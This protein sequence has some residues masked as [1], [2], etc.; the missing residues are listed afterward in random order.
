MSDFDDIRKR[1][2]ISDLDENERKAWHDKFVKAGGKDVGEEKKKKSIQIDR[3][4]QRAMSE[5]VN[6]RR[7]RRREE[8]D[9]R[10]RNKKTP[11]S[12][13]KPAEE[14]VLSKFFFKISLY[15]EGVFA[16]ATD[17]SGAFINP[18]VLKY[19]E[20]NVLEDLKVS[21]AFVGAI[22]FPTGENEEDA[23]RKREVV[24]AMFKNTVNY[25]LLER[26][27]AMY[28][29]TLYEELLKEYRRN[30]NVSVSIE[31]KRKTI[32]AL[33][34]G[35]Y[36][37]RHEYK[38]LED[39]IDKG[40]E[41]YKSLGAAD[42]SIG[43]QRKS[44]I[45]RV[46]DALFYN[47]YDKF[48]IYIKH[49]AK[50]DF[51]LNEKSHVKALENFIEMKDEDYVGYYTKQ[52]I[53][54]EKLEEEKNEVEESKK[55]KKEK[56]T[57]SIDDSTKNGIELI[58]SLVKFKHSDNET[59]E[60]ASLEETDKIFRI[61]CVL[62][63][64]EREYSLALT[65]N[66][67]KYD[68]YGG[69][70]KKKNY[71]SSFNE[72]YAEVSDI[73]NRIEKYAHE[74]FDIKK[75]EKDTTMR[76]ETRLQRLQRERANCSNE[77]RGTK[78]ALISYLRKIYTLLTPLATDEDVLKSAILNPDEI[79]EFESALHGKKRLSG[80]SVRDALKQTHDFLSG[81]LYMISEGSL[82]GAG[83]LIE[84]GASDIVDEEDTEEG[85]EKS[86]SEE[87]DFDEKKEKTKLE[88]PS[89][90]KKEANNM[91]AF[92][93]EKKYDEAKNLAVA[94]LEDAEGF[95]AL[96]IKASTVLMSIHH[97]KSEYAEVVKIYEEHKD[98]LEEDK[99]C[100]AV[101]AKAKESLEE[102]GDAQSE[103][104]KEILSVVSKVEYELRQIIM[105]AYS[106]LGEA[107][108][109]ER[110]S[111]DEVGK[112]I[113]TAL[114]SAK[115]K[116]GKKSELLSY[117]N[118]EILLSS[119]VRSRQDLLSSLEG[120]EK[121]KVAEAVESLL[122]TLRANE[123][124]ALS[125]K[126]KIKSLNEEEASSFKDKAHKVYEKTREIK[127]ILSIV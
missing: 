117:A 63:I 5:R 120:N 35:I 87:R 42:K 96:L 7:E 20:R 66:K 122:K 1:T 80:L 109:I 16:G 64:F 10:D 92:Y 60:F 13:Q 29:E 72:A 83:L 115:Q 119:L 55:E 48:F 51:R 33:F 93:N 21:D 22:L 105:R 27:R 102:T 2:H 78:A 68:I 47:V 98:I 50:R 32:I 54:I 86:D 59:N 36:I 61:K 107:G 77:A 40:L 11:S 53:V 69:G 116:S 23:S 82:S 67:I 41:A 126:S 37:L 123:I 18:K 112:K 57:P 81:F 44:I 4:A 52:R 45:K 74:F 106:S 9:E 100:R 17:S 73:E 104:I 97:K 34:K 125:H 90:L 110:L 121:I 25:E 99:V 24:L 58:S 71:S 26:F 56:K 28:S 46:M 103:T 8:Y 113:V 94:L 43:S 38:A 15:F 65:T 70:S 3:N 12:S 6:R 91:I 108:L 30:R 95:D 111:K 114:T 118:L 101:Y 79:L 39:A 31:S 88:T 49:Y 84:E 76:Y 85:D 62:D 89:H 127:K 124:K 14:S 19:I 75:L